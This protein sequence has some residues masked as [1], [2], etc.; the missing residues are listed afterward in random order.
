MTPGF[1]S[2]RPSVGGQWRGMDKS[3]LAVSWQLLALVMWVPFTCEF[4]G[5]EKSEMKEAHPNTWTS[6]ASTAGP[7]E[8]SDGEADASIQ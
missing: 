5:K 2:K 3:R 6:Q 7:L 4:L 8:R 1:S